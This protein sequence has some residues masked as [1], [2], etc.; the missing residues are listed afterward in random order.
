VRGEYWDKRK[1]TMKREELEK[2]QLKL[3][4]WQIKRCYERSS[5]YRIK[6]KKAGVKPE[7]IKK[8]DDI[9]K[10]PFVYKGELREE[11]RQHGPYR[12]LVTSNDVIEAYATTGTTGPQVLSFWTRNDREYIVD[13]TARTLWAM[14]MRPGLKVQNAFSYELWPPGFAVHFAVQKIG[15]FVLPIGSGKS[16]LQVKFI[17]ELQ[18]DVFI[19][20]PTLALKIGKRLEE[21]GIDPTELSLKFGAFGGDIGA[22]IPNTRKMIE[23][24]LNI[25]AYDYYGIVEIGPTFAGEC[26]EKAGLHWSEDYH[27]VEVVDPNSGER[28]TEGEKG[29]LVVTHLVKEATP[30]IRYWTGDLTTIEYEKCGCGRTHARSPRGIIGR[31]DDMITYQ[32]IN[33]YPSDIENIIRSYPELGIEYIIKIERGECILEVEY[34]GDRETA[35]KLKE[36]LQEKIKDTIGIDINVRLVDRILI[37]YVGMKARRKVDINLF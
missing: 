25:D 22:A 27:L 12:Y 4:K 13:V 18:P 14:G 1:E 16:I 17:I 26:K 23:K 2:L 37:P 6:F 10:I 19:S 29:V 8:L 7:D 35:I 11:Q 24:L 3:L 20:T 36:D 31:T 30:M 15:G 9:E 5:F 28:V 34:N 32:G 33:F 21:M